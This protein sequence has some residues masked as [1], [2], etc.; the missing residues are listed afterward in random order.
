[1]VAG[2]AL[3]NSNEDGVAVER[4]ER[5]LFAVRKF[6]NAAGDVFFASACFSADEDGCARGGDLLHEFAH[7]AHFTR[8]ANEFAWNPF[9]RQGNAPSCLKGGDLKTRMRH[10]ANEI[11]IEPYWKWLNYGYGQPNFGGAI[12]GFRLV[13]R[14]K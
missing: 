4:D 3:E 14:L 6:M 7:F 5:T 11:Y 2:E 8:V 13:R 9:K 10:S 12:G 1:M